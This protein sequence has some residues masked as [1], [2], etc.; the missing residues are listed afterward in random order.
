MNR[1]ALAAIGAAAA[2]SLTLAACGSSSGDAPEDEATESGPVELSVAVWSLDQTPEFQALS[3]AF[4]TDNPDITI[5][6]VD[7]LADDYPEKVTTML[8]GGDT[9]DV[10]TRRPSRTTRATPAAA[11]STTSPTGHRLPGR[12]AG[13]HRRLRGGRQVLRGPVPPGLLGPVLQQGPL[14]RGRRR[15]PRPRGRGTSTPTSRRS[16]TGTDAAG[17]KV[18]GTYNHVWQSVMQAAA[19][20][21]TEG[22]DL[23]SGDYGFLKDQYDLERRPAEGRLRARLLDGQ[24]PAGHLPGDVRDAGHRDAAD[25][26][27][28][29]LRD[30]AGHGGRQVHGRVGHR[31]RCRRSTATDGTTDVR[32]PDRVRASTRRRSTRTPPR[33]SSRSPRRSRAPRRS[34]RSASRPA[35][36]SDEVTAAYFALEGM[37]TDDLSK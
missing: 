16:C 33:R 4:E 1:K 21:Q 19:Q 20:A 10:I 28:V 26:H 25:G 2:L 27:L 18:Y 34:P 6:P 35:L 23:L 17:Q 13:R 3:D 37:P 7:I 9:T 8:A 5:K 22:A 12:Q 30:P 24:D 36:Q 29:R 11:S 32:R 14:R 15:L 31:A